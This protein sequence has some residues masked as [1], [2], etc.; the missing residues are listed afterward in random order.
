MKASVPAQRARLLPLIA[1]LV[2]VCLLALACA[3]SAK[4]YTP[5]DLGDPDTTEGPNHG[6]TSAKTASNTLM[7]QIEY[8]TDKAASER[9][10]YF[11]F[12]ARYWVLM[13]SLF[14]H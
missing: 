10:E 3:A 14:L 5:I 1:A 2:V 12:V 6:G 7:V 13:R 9:G 8:S 11:Y 4:P